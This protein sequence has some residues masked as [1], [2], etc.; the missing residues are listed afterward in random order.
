[1]RLYATDTYII[2]LTTYCTYMLIHVLTY[3][4]FCSKDFYPILLTV[5]KVFGVL[6]LLSSNNI[7]LIGMS[8]YW[9]SHFPFISYSDFLCIHVN[10]HWLGLEP[11]TTST[12]IR[13][14]PK[15]PPSSPR[16]NLT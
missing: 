6:L 16:H 1:M 5:G 3:I 14:R 13:R 2:Y 9:Y 12:T 11:G 4:H 15:R 7:L 10:N 8:I